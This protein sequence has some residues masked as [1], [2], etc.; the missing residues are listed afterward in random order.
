MV[1]TYMSVLSGRQY[2]VV[3]AIS[4]DHV[5]VRQTAERLSMTE[6]AVRVT[7]HRAIAALAKAYRGDS[8]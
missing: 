1:E 6:G 5:S 8:R 7:L 4:L 2:E 3:K